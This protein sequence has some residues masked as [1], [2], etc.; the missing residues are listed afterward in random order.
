MESRR[1]A[2]IPLERAAFCCAGH[3][4]PCWDPKKYPICSLFPRRT[5]PFWGLSLGSSRTVGCRL[6]VIMHSGDQED[7]QKELFESS[8]FLSIAVWLCP[9]AD[10]PADEDH[11]I[12]GFRGSSAITRRLSMKLLGMQPGT[13]S[14]DTLPPEDLD[15]DQHM[16]IVR[17]MFDS[18]SVSPESLIMLPIESTATDSQRTNHP[19]CRQAERPR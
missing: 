18:Q 1:L 11:L 7:W 9:A 19:I 4:F 10:P 14:V 8:P 17:G 16:D 13:W 6:L 2:P 5:I 3:S 15:R 12:G